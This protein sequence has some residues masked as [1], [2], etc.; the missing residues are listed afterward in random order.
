MACKQVPNEGL[1]T[2]DKHFNEQFMEIPNLDDSIAFTSFV[3]N[4]KP[5]KFK[6]D[7]LTSE[8]S[9]YTVALEKARK[10]TQALEIQ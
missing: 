8:V 5:S 4:L 7:L 1:M 2:F 10:F 6:I 9:S 3:T